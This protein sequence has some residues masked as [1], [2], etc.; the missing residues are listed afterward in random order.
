MKNISNHNLRISKKQLFFEQEES[1]SLIPPEVTCLSYCDLES[2][3]DGIFSNG[4]NVTP[5]S[6]QYSLRNR[7]KLKGGIL[8]FRAT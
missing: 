6:V 3:I 7:V 5:A 2:S 1:L 8:I 4:M